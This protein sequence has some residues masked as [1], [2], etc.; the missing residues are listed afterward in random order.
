[1]WVIL[2]GIRG[3]GEGNELQNS[4]QKKEKRKKNYIK[5]TYFIEKIVSFFIFFDL[6]LR[7]WRE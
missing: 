3:G 4:T 7:R 5:K 6:F 1:L 2:E